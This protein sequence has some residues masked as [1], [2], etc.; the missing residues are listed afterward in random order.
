MQALVYTDIQKLI[1]REEKNPKLL[2]GESIIKVSASGI[3]GSD[4]H[5]YHGHDNRRIPPLI[6]GH[7][8]SGVIN[9]GKDIGKKVVLNP[10]ITCGTCSYC[11]NKREHLCP[12]RIILGMN[13][14]IERQGGFAEYVSIPDKNIYSLPEN[15]NIKE[16]PIAEPCAVALH[17]VE[18][19]ENELSEEL[20]DSK[21]LVIGAG[22]IGLLCGLILSKVKKCKEIVIIEPNDKR[23]EK[24]LKYLDANGFKPSSKNIL[25][26]HFNI[27][28]DTVGLEVTRK[29]AID[30]I[31]PG[32]TIIHIGLTQPSGNFDFR[33]ATLQEITFIGTYCYTNRDFEKTLSI[34]NN[35]EIGSLE[36]IE[37]RELKDGASAFK[38]IHEGSC[39]SPK[40]ILLV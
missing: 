26:D 20:K 15:L 36:W 39:S 8:V 13:R 4:M 7:E 35:K 27:V 21:V 14:P 12:K 30:C 25:K 18:L 11:E 38:H 1:Y 23:L 37:Y 10:L 29:Q 2:K 32:G 40:I 16:A 31:K 3:C 9:K 19:G 6:L 22:A 33:K 28:F 17:A 5:A 34:L 24:S